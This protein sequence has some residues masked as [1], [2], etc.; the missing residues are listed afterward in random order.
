MGGCNPRKGTCFRF[1]GRQQTIPYRIAGEHFDCNSMDGCT[2]V[3]CI[4]VMVAVQ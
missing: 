1:D 2:V 3:V 4:E